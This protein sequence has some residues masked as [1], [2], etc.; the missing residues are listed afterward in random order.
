M[1]LTLFFLG[2]TPQSSLNGLRDSLDELARSAKPFTLSL[3][4]MGCFPTCHQPRVL[5]V[6]LGQGFAEARALKAKLDQR[7]KPLGWEPEKRL[8]NPHLTIGR[9]RRQARLPALNIS[10][11]LPTLS[12]QAAKINLYQSELTSSGP[13]YTVRHTAIF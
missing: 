13:R 12:W 6:G 3:G 5:W 4:A 10:R 11:D 2:D 7:L 9:A 1:H 8:Y